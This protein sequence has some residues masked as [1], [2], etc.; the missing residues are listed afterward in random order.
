MVAILSF[1]V[2]SRYLMAS[3]KP[4]VIF[5]L[6]GPGAGMYSKICYS[7]FIIS[8]D[9]GKGTQCARIAKVSLIFPD[10]MKYIR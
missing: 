5:V 1:F 8:F 9:L 10:F 7:L 3:V 2:V 4:N 6:G